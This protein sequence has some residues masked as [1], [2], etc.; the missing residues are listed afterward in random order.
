MQKS[1]QEAAPKDAGD[2]ASALTVFDRRWRSTTKEFVVGANGVA[3]AAGA[4]A[5]AT[6]AN[7]PAIAYAATGSLREFTDTTKNNPSNLTGMVPP[8]EVASVPECGPSPL[9]PEKIKTLVEQAARRHQVDAF[10]ATAI[11]W[12]ESRFDQSRNS[13]K[14]A[15]GP[16]QL[17]PETAARFGVQDA[18]DPEANIEGGVKYLRVLL[19]QF[20]NPLL[21][22]AA[23]NAGESRIYEYGGIP[24]FKET[25]S[26]VAQVVNYQIGIPMP[27]LKNR[28]FG[29]DAKSAPV[30]ASRAESGVIAVKKT[31]TFVGGVMHF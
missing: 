16:M 14:G 22:A 28:A 15:R 27:A 11:A 6:E 20:R 30:L 12:T 18:C 24:P 4:G 21:V 19:D 23:Y 7:N 8:K 9:P 29:K 17:M 13:D 10:F 25:V 26:Y 3:M 2:T 31:G 5:E 1:E